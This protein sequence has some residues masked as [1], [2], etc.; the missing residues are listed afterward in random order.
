[1]QPSILSQDQSMPRKKSYSSKPACQNFRKT[2]ASTHSWKR[3]WA[4]EPGQKRVAFKAFH[5]QPVRST[6]RMAS[7]QT[8]SGA[9]GRPP[10]KRWVF[11]WGGSSSCMPSHMASGI[12]QSSGTGCSS[13][14]G[15]LRLPAAVPSQ[16][17]LHQAVIAPQ[18]L[19]G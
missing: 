14:A 10:P 12:R 17:Q 6:N 9:R 4:V 11:L 2:P 3:S 7:I 1:M 18:G 15:E 16:A 5:W 8:R 13:M 19:F